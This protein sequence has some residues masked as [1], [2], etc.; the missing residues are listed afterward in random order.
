MSAFGYVDRRPPTTNRTAWA[1]GKPIN[2]GSPVRAPSMVSGRQSDGPA[3]LTC[4]YPDYVVCPACGEL[5]VEV[6]CYAESARCHAC[7][8]LIPHARAHCYRSEGCAAPE[9]KATS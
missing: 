4:P 3:P 1:G 6:W 5:E 2:Q 9:P 7:G 8:T